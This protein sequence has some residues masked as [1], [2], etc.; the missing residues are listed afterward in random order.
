MLNQEAAFPGGWLLPL[1]LNSL[2]QVQVQVQVSSPSTYILL[3]QKSDP[4]P[5]VIDDFKDVQRARADQERLINEAQAYA[6]RIVPEAKGE[7]SKIRES[8]EA[9]KQEVIAIADGDSQRF[10][11]VYKE[12]KEAKDVTRRRIYLETMEKVMQNMNKVII[13]NKM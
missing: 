11:S 7:A 8:A 9:Y 13:D 12:Y 5:A 3:L 4:P 1:H 10:L 2:V 6:N